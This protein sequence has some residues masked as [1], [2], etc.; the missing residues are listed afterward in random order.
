VIYMPGRRFRALA[1]DLIA[2]G[3]DPATPCVAVSKAST[4]EERV[5]AATLADV[6]DANIGPA[7]VL[8]LIGQAV[9]IAS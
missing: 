8:L 1:D 9:R 7:P 3:I 2:S 6:E 5:Y 4:T